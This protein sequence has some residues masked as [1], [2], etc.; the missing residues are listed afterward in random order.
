MWAI[1]EVVTTCLNLVVT[2]Y[3]LNQSKG[4]WL[5][6][7]ALVIIINLIMAME[8]RLDPKFV[9]GSETCD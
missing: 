4:Q 5:L 7:D 3:V 8:F 1:V 6:S 2:T 9:D